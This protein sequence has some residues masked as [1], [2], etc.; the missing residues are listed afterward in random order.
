MT[1][2]RKRIIA[3][4]LSMAMV[5]S[6]NTINVLA[7]VNNVDSIN[8]PITMDTTNTNT[9]TGYI[10][11]IT[12]N[13]EALVPVLAAA[14][15][16]GEDC[17]AINNINR[18]YLTADKVQ[19]GKIVV[20]WADK[21]H[22]DL[23]SGNVLANIMFDVLPDAKCDFRNS[24]GEFTTVNAKIYQVARYPDIMA[25]GE[26]SYTNNYKLND[27][28]AHNFT[29]ADNTESGSSVYV[30]DIITGYEEN[31]ID[32]PPVI[33]LPIVFAL[34]QNDTFYNVDKEVIL[35]DAESNTTLFEK[36]ASTVI[37]E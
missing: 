7:D 13:P 10:A 36:I 4:L 22:Y 19:E 2:K 1:V 23:E 6:C 30:E 16:L 9:V 25:D 32:A 12:Y 31:N 35:D 28:Y 37:I 18:G 29:I 20:G 3:T 17:Y 21:E 5:L 26:Y 14:D 24:E 27:N 11:E 33:D 8:V 34:S 15:V